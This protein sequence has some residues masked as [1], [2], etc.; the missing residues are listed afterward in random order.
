[1]KIAA[2][3]FNS[4]SHDARVLKEAE[5]LAK[6]GHQVTL[7]G[8]C[9]NRNQR[10]LEPVFPGFEIRRVVWR[11]FMVR[12]G[13]LWL[14]LF[15]ALAMLAYAGLWVLFLRLPPNSKNFVYQCTF[16]FC[17]VFFPLL[18]SAF[19]LRTGI[20]FCRKPAAA[21]Q[22]VPDKKV[23]PRSAL[24]F[25]RGQIHKTFTIKAVEAAIYSEL[26]KIRPDAVHCHDLTTLPVG[27]KWKRRNGGKLVYDS[28]EIF[29]KTAG[30][31]E[32]RSR[33]WEYLQNNLAK[34]ADAFIT[35]NNSIAEYLNL[36]YKQLPK[37][38]VVM[39]AAKYTEKLPQY[40]GRLHAAAGVDRDVS[41]LLYQGGFSKHRGLEK[42]IHAGVLLPKNWVLVMMGWGALQESLLSAAKLIDPAEK[43]IRFLPGVPQ[44]ELPLWTQGGALGIIPYE[45]VCM[46]HWFCT[47][48]KIWEYTS[49]KVPLLVSPF[50]ELKRIIETH[51]VGWLLDEILTGENIS[52]AV[53]RITCGGLAE[54][55][56]NCL[57]FAEQDNWSVY[58]KRLTAIYESF[59]KP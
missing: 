11:F 35:V 33:Y 29:E 47:P 16:I 8:I 50:P 59:Q 43:K 41:I 25:I 12:R 1:M 23:S 57:R 24:D 31:S 21:Q 15:S 26:K 56:E 20:R 53:G 17:T 37:A 9:D 7:I 34:Y 51:Q 30:L 27:V 2:I 42:L 45:N 55:R 58:E 48:N 46:N 54:K 32:I 36:K 49:A 39:N 19:A 52:A 5:S 28:H 38:V 44:K 4:V 40:D 3:V 14:G 10:Q 6:A 22:S 13:L 18:L